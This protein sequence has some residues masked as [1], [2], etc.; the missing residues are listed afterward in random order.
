MTYRPKLI[1]VALPLDAINEASAKEKSIRHGHPSTLHLWWA[2]RP[3]AACRAVLF[4]QLVDDPSGWPE[5]F[6]TEEAQDNERERIFDIVREFVIW[7]NSNNPETIYKARLEIAR[8]FARRDRYAAQAEGIDSDNVIEMMPRPPAEEVNKYL[9]T[10]VPPVHDPFAGGGSIPL[11]A[12]RLGLRAIATDQ[13]PVPVLINKAQLDFPHRFVG[14]TPISDRTT[15]LRSWSGA[16]AIGADLR[17]YAAIMVAEARSRLNALYPPLRVTEQMVAG[18]PDLATLVGSELTVIA[19][20]WARTV[21]SPNPAMRGAEVP[22]L[23]TF[24]LSKRKGG[25]TWLMPEVDRQR[26]S[27]RLVARRGSAPAGVDEGTKVGRGG[28]RCILSDEPIPADYLREMGRQGKIGQRMVG[29]VAEGRRGRHF[30]S[31]VQEH[32]VVA[33]KVRAPDGAPDTSLPERA[34]GFSPPGYGFTTHASLFTNRQLTALV[35]FAE[36]I[37]EARDR[38]RADA[39]AAGWPDGEALSEGGNGAQAYAD[40]LAVYLAFILDKTADGS[41][42]LCRWMV[43]RDSL[44]NTFARNALQMVWDFAEVN[45]LADCTRSFSESAKWTAESVEGIPVGVGPIGNCEVAPAQSVQAGRTCVATDPPYYDNVPYADLSDFFYV[46]LRKSLLPV[47]PGLFKTMLVPK[48]PELV[49]EPARFSGSRA[50]ARDFFERGMLQAFR[51][52]ALQQSPDLPMTVYYAFKQEEADDEPADGDVAAS[53]S[54]GWETMLSALVEAGLTITGT[55]PV[56]T[57]RAAR[58]RDIG[59]NALASSMVLVCRGRRSDAPSCTRADFRRLLRVELPSAMRHLQ[60][61]NIAPVDVA[62]AAIGPGMGIFSRHARVVEADGRPMTVRTALQLI[63]EALDEFLS[64]SEGELDSDSRFAVSWF[65][66]Y[67]YD[68]GPFGVAENIAKGRNVSVSGVAEAGILTASAGKVRLHRRSELPAEWNPATDKQLTVWEATQ[69]LIKRLEEEG[70]GPAAELLKALG[71]VADQARALAYRLY[72]AC[73]R[74]KWAEEA[75]AYNGLVVAWPELERL[76]AQV[77]AAK[78]ATKQGKLF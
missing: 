19:W 38:I 70:E 58:A 29:I 21:P 77:V 14:R 59:A 66:T 42:T 23:S 62:Q 26:A 54:T 50:A 28:F 44:F 60:H 17:H 1:E 33:T 24:W 74:R 36:L 22:L 45:V 35:T 15:R 37:G 3:L 20:L 56:S 9:A 25:E 32:E 67:G 8:T 16:A 52:L 76:A 49:A 18:R 34:L 40:A 78:P 72:S 64:E 39:Q 48:G 30:F 7:E 6:P 27:W 75:R 53:S 65:E 61:G 71:P 13:N 46:W 68:T 73:E 11:E 41:S 4:G 55:W 63:N 69:H 5:E 47:L 43:Q 57:E 51:S 12:Q 31:A 10:R 2:R